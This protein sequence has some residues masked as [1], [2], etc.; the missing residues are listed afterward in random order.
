MIN[1]NP[2]NN[3]EYMQFLIVG[4]DHEKVQ[5]LED[6]VEFL[7]YQHNGCKVADWQKADVDEVDIVIVVGCQNVHLPSISSQYNKPMI[8]AWEEGV[9]KHEVENLHPTA[10]I[11]FPL[12]YDEF[13]D[14]LYL[15][16]SQSPKQNS[17]LSVSEIRVLKTLVGRSKPVRVIHKQ[18]T[19][20]S[21]TDANVLILGPSG[22][23]KEVVAHCLHMLSNRSKG[24]FIPVNCGAIP[25]E[26]LESELFGHEKGAFTGAISARHGRFEM[27]QGGTLFLDEIGD[28]PTPMQVKLLRVLQ[29][30]T[31]ERVGGSKP[32]QA[33]VRI[34][35]ATHRDLEEHVA[36]GSFREDLFYRLNV[37]PIDMPCL[38]ERVEDIP[39][40]IKELV[41]RYEKQNNVYIKMTDSAIEHL[42]D[43]AWPG[44]V[45]ELANLIERLAIINPNGIVDA[46]DLP[47]KYRS[48]AL[49]MDS[50]YDEN[51]TSVSAM[52]ADMLF[53]DLE[54]D[55]LNNAQ[56]GDAELPSDG[57]DLKEYLNELE[58]NFI[59]QALDECDWVVARAAERVNLRRT[60]LVEKM[61]KYG[62]AR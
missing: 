15:C 31:F 16:Q 32:I 46:K 11:D 14:A 55:T 54:E 3:V 36:N 45:R 25:A 9:E 61:K 40:L 4:D 59:T 52:E 41:G 19:Q 23:G 24:P 30:R 44:N 20:V 18:I 62:L 27:A 34:V 2:I 50:N 38:S 12:H 37:F 39:L 58:I 5:T 57:I 8:I 60:T 6:I 47:E 7:N 43:Y 33:D 35:A 29:E 48:D 56:L 22:T 13:I 10:E 51:D 26:L 21:P 53:D 42:K 17:K 28:M 49:P 1:A